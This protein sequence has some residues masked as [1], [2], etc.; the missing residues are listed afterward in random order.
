ML[1]GGGSRPSAVAAEA[2]RAGGAEPAAELIE[3][4]LDLP[5]GEQALL[6]LGGSR[7][8][9]GDDV[10]QGRRRHRRARIASRSGSTPPC[11]SRKRA[12]QSDQL[13]LLGRRARCPRSQGRRA[14]RTPTPV[15]LAAGDLAGQPDALA[16]QEQEVEP[17]VG[18]PFVLED[19]PEAADLLDLG[20]PLPF[21]SASGRS[22][23]D[24][25]E[26]V[27][28]PAR[29]RSSAGSAARRCAAAGRRAGRGRPGSGNSRQ[30]LEVPQVEIVVHGRPAD[31]PSRVRRRPGPER[32]CSSVRPERQGPAG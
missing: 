20:D 19:P 7:Q 25:H 27:G 2:A 15:E 30:T 9:V 26:P 21:H 8:G 31:D 17:A 23:D 22:M 1:N 28:R 14:P 11:G 12:E 6:D 4:K 29:P 13:G 18:E 3:P 10:G 24:R 16:A 5:L 32:H